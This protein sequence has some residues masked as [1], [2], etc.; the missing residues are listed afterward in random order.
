[1]NKNYVYWIVGAIVVIGIGYV[2]MQGGS[3]ATLTP[4][5]EDVTTTPST[6][7]TTDTSTSGTT[8]VSTGTPGK[9]IV[10]TIGFA[11]VSSTT[12]MVVGN[13]IPEGAKT[14]Y[15]FEYGPTPALGISVNTAEIVSGYKKI[16]VTTSIVGLKPSTQYY[17][18]LGAKNAY[19]T[20]YGGPYSF[21]TAAQ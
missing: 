7:D 1:M 18:R 6:P 12:V 14:T 15:W 20:V 13:V 2:L 4:P 19:G 3:S 5:T 21:I 8:S 10:T 9:P 16:G 17:F 11:S